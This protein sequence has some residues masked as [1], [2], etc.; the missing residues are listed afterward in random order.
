MKHIEEKTLEKDL[1]IL[2]KKSQKRSTLSI[3]EILEILS[4]KGRVL[5]LIFLTLPFCQP[6]QI[7]GFSTPFGIMIA[8][9]GLRMAFGKR[10][11]L[12]KTILSKNVSSTAIQ[13]ITKKG[14]QIIKK[15][16]RFMRPRF[17]WLCDQGPLK[18]ANGILIFFLGILLAIPLPIPFT[19]LSAG[20]S[21]FLISLGALE[22]D[23]LFVLLGYLASL[24]TLIFFT[25]IF[26]S[27]KSI[28]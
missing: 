1:S 11:W 3:G 19:N 5:I 15:M 24:I 22:S 14:L 6:L 16:R 23:E 21:I 4:G 20:C 10:M 12:P 18:I 27:L 17:G 13:K 26:F 9:I 7:P 25:F 2:L 8:F 28:F